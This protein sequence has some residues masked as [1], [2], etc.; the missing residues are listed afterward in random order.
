[1]IP[2]V[3]Q[4]QD[5]ID[6][7]PPFPFP[8]MSDQ[9]VPEGWEEIDVLLCDTSGVGGT[10]EPAYTPDQLKK[11]LEVGKGYAIVDIGMFQLQLGVF[12]PPS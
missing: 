6:N 12:N 10:G 9:D 4:S 11:K 1:M 7:F 3:I 2:K 8:D 5:E